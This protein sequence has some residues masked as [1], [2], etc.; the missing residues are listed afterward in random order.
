M[1][2][3]RD[4]IKK[5]ESDMLKS[6]QSTIDSFMKGETKV[7]TRNITYTPLGQ[8]YTRELNNAAFYFYKTTE[9]PM[10]IAKALQWSARANELYDSEEAMDTYAHL[11][12][13]TGNKAEA[14]EWLSQAI[15]LR[16]EHGFNTKLFEDELAKMKDGSFK[17]DNH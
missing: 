7:Y 4:S 3:T 14:I 2:V 9:N 12:F 16:K 6:R 15:E 13:K 11:L 5:R 1:T 8:Y 17:R 10:H